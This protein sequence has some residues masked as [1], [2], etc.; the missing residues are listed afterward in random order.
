MRK[1]QLWFITHQ[2][3]LLLHVA[4]K[5]ALWSLSLEFKFLLWIFQV[6]HQTF[7][8]SIQT[9]APVL[10]HQWGSTETCIVYVRFPNREVHNCILQFHSKLWLLYQHG[11][12]LVQ[13]FLGIKRTL[14]F[15]LVRSVAMPLLFYIY[16]VSFLDFS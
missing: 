6:F 4:K 10:E 1:F 3:V 8:V 11:M 14:L 13:T 9:C 5:I 15:L 12:C 7:C 2:L 16:V